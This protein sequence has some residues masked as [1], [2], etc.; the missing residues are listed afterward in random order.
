MVSGGNL[1]IR[2]LTEGT[3]VMLRARVIAVHSRT[4]VLHVGDS[5]G[6]ELLEVAHSEIFR[7][8]STDDVAGVLALAID[9]VEK[10]RDIVLRAQAEVYELGAHALTPCIKSP[11]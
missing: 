9:R 3:G 11:A 6:G 5:R 8:D 7:P 2:D 10:L 1:T 4:C